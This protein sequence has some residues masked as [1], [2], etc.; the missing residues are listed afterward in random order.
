MLCCKN[1]GK[2]LIKI[3]R[4]GKKRRSRKSF[5]NDLCQ[6]EYESKRKEIENFKNCP[7][8]GTR[9]LYKGHA[10]SFKYFCSNKCYGLSIAGQVSPFKGKCQSEEVLAKISKAN[11]GRPCTEEAKKKLS[12]IGKGRRHTKEHSDKIS[13]SLTGKEHTRER[14]KNQRLARIKYIEK[15]KLK[16]IK[17]C[18]SAN[19]RGCEYFEKFDKEHNTKGQYASSGGEFFISDLGFWVDYINRDLKLI[20]EYDEKRHYYADGTLKEK[21][22]KRQADIEKLYPDYKFV[23]IKEII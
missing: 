6:K 14:I 9:F 20:M 17:L 21:D 19:L 4:N 11:T 23:R 2:E 15:V 22:Q 8:C 5:C 12:K 16:G 1:C 7:I 10:K 18:P 3:I 13:K